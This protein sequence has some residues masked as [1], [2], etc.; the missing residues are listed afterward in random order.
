MMDE[1]RIEVVEE[2]ARPDAEL[3]DQ[4]ALFETK[5]AWVDVWQGMP[6]YTHQDLSPY[7]T[8]LV[9]FRNEADRQ[10]FAQLVNQPL[11]EKT[12]FI[13]YPKVEIGRAA[14][15]LFTVDEHVVPRYPVYIISKGRWETRYTSKALEYINVPYHIVVEPQEYDNYAAVIDPAKIL[16]LPFSNLGL[17]GIP[18]RNWVWEHAV[19]I[20]AA[21]HWI[22]DDNIQGW[23]RFQ[24]NLKVEIKSGVAFRLIEDWTDR[25]ENVVMSGFNYDYFAP[26]KEAYKISPITLNTRVY[27][28]IL[29]RNDMPH[30]WR[31][32]YNEDT[33]LSLRFLKDGWCTALFNALLMYK[34][35]TMKQKGGNTDQ[36]YA[37]AEQSAADW[38][39]HAAACKTCAACLDGYGAEKHPCPDGTGILERDGRW[40]M[41]EH[42]RLQHP[43]VTTV[44]RK[45]GRWQHQVDY[46]RFRGN[47]LKLKDDAAPLRDYGISITHLTDDEQAA[48]LAKFRQQDGQPTPRA[49]KPTPR[50]AKPTPPVVAPASASVTSAAPATQH[51]V[52]E[53]DQAACQNYDATAVEVVSQ[54][55]A[56]APPWV[57]A[58]PPQLDGVDTMAIDTETT[59][60]NWRGGDALVGISIA[61]PGGRK[62]YLPVGHRGGGNL[63]ESVV[64]R[65]AERELRGKTLYG[66]NIKFDVH[67]LREWG[68]DLEAQGCRVSDI[69]HHAAL[70]DDHRRK[71]SLEVLSQEFLK[72]GKVGGLNKERMADYA[73][74]DVAAYAEEDAQL[75][76]ELKDVFAPLLAADGLER[77]LQLEEDLIF[78]VCEMERQG[79]PLDMEL[80]EQWTRD[81]ERELNEALISVAR[82]VGFQVNPDKG[83]DW[84]RL[85]AARG[86]PVTTFTETGA[87]SFTDAVLK[88]VDD[89]VVQLA[90]RA[91][92]IASIRSKYL[93]AYTESAVSGRL[94]YSL[95]QLRADEHGTISGR[96]SSSDKNIQQVMRVSSQR[97]AF[98]YDAKDSS[99][100]DQI[101]PIRRLFV[102]QNGRWLCADARQIEYRL[103]AHYSNSPKILEAYRKDPLLSYHKLV[104]SEV[105]P[106]KPGV[107]YDK[108]KTLNFALVYGGGKDTVARLLDMSRDESDAFVALYHRLFPEVKKLLTTAQSLAEVR[109][110]VK[111]LLGRRSRFPDKKFTHKALNA[112]IQPCAA[113]IMKLKVVELHAERKQTGFV[114]RY[115]VHDEVDGDSP[116]DE[117]TLKVQEILDR[118]SLPTRVPILWEVGTGANWAEAK[119]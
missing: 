116:S 55:P 61:L 118:Q 88:H 115:P 71:F 59:G 60:L 92:K 20:G 80:L 40:R 5:P 98:G 45:W 27:S 83:A 11:S 51:A 52:P 102:P 37:G 63:D 82:S 38:Q 7:K 56:T 58:A 25:Y 22:L 41:A 65:W 46:R 79:A 109:G 108:A 81:S 119:A 113:D 103:F 67:V 97:E 28:G 114:M 21:R 48:E 85:F 110:Y 47:P 73:A 101:Y 77:V 75:V 70:I 4:Q 36:L 9:H 14:N 93:L 104:H 107:S 1:S 15:K 68:V 8:L 53:L 31:G 99:H 72:R 117:T 2:L 30:R 74:A 10:A 42:L 12:K 111:T 50:A 35:P 90:R 89:P 105:E 32:R 94:H 62:Q 6:D 49:A 78:P 112:L 96:F 3:G 87:P 95:H 100:D 13:W 64:R 24:D 106:F 84:E 19:S 66:A 44:E 18:A 26:R 91:G 57:A 69:Q 43:D 17:G 16:T 39:A 29:L 33:D 23:C 86:I 34:Q 76:L 54:P